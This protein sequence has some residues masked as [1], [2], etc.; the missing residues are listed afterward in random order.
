MKKLIIITVFSFFSVSGFSQT[1]DE[2]IKEIQHYIQTT[3]Q[4][5]CLSRRN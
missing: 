2:N 4:N 5:E 1:N 3:S